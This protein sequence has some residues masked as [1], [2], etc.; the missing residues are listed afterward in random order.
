MG[1]LFKQATVQF[2]GKY[3]EFRNIPINY[4]TAKTRTLLGFAHSSFA[5]TGNSKKKIDSCTE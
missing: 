4:K 5:F 1:K 3:C 2:R